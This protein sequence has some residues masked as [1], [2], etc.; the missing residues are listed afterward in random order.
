[1]REALERF[2]TELVALRRASPHTAAAY[3]RDIAALLD[4]SGGPGRPVAPAAWT[5]ELLERGVRDLT[6]GG[7]SARSVARALSA[8]R[9]FSRFCLRRGIIAADPA[10]ALRNPRLPQ[11]LPTPLPADLLERALNALRG[12]DRA[13]LRDRA[14]LEVAYSSGLR[15]SELVSLNHG[16]L[17]RRSQVVRVRGKGRRERITPIGRTALAALGTY[18]EAEART[19]GAAG[20]AIF[21]GRS[22]RRL[23]ARTVQRIVRRRLAH[24]A[25]GMKVSPHTLRHSFATHLLNHGADLRA[26]QEM[27]GHKS[28][29]TTQIYTHVS[30]A[31]LRKAYDQ[32]HPRA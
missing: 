25:L 5:R 29:R 1:V 8:W 9:A 27:L 30:R 6:V 24:M 13:A 14:L 10:L 32:A 20:E 19:G 12:P 23:T 31:H 7:H 3:G 28:L 11:R 26:I 2:L 16:D 21:A 15:V 22:G 18:L 4:R 17:D